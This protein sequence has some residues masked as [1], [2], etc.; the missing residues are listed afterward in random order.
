MAEILYIVFDFFLSMD[1]GLDNKIVIITGGANGIGAATAKIFAKEGAIPVF[2]DIDDESGYKLQKKIGKKKSLYMHVDVTKKKES[3]KAIEHVVDTY[4]GLDILV[5]N[6]GVNDGASLDEPVAKFNKSLTLNL[7]SHYLIT[8]YSWKYLK[9]NKGNIVNIASKVAMTGQGGTS[10]YAA[11]KG[12]LLGL[13]R[14][15]AVE[16]LN[17]NIRVNAIL[18]A[19]VYTGMYKDWLNE[20]FKNPEVEKKR[21]EKNIPLGNRM[22]KPKEIAYAVAFFASNKVSGHTTAQIF[23]PDGG[24]V[25]L[26]RKITL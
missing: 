19:E 6:V 21:I 5:N 10:G 9:K 14:E 4:G 23:S 17:H 2:F 16:G 26:D 11:A 12:A 25:H 20:A 1:L 22:T 7:E 24:Y 8:K 15:W 13:T 18:P 3:K